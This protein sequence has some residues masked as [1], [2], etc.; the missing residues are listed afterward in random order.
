MYHPMRRCRHELAGWFSAAIGELMLPPK[1][2]PY[3]Q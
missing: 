1:A 3:W 2:D